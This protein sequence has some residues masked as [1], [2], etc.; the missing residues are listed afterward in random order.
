MF[1]MK[2][3]YKFNAVTYL[4]CTTHINYIEKYFIKKYNYDLNTK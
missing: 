1:A 4:L 2:D 3:A